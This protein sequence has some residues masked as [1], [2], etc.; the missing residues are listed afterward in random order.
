[1]YKNAVTVIFDRRKT[2]SKRGYGM[3]ELRIFIARNT[4]KYISLENCTPSQWDEAVFSERYADLR[5]KYEDVLAAMEL[6][7]ANMDV[8][9]FCQ[10][11]GLET[12]E[13]A[14]KKAEVETASPSP[15]PQLGMPCFVYPNGMEQM[16]MAPNFILHPSGVM[17]PLQMKDSR[18]NLEQDFLE[19]MQTSI[20]SEN[21]RKGTYKHKQT[22]IEA[23]RRFGKIKTFADLTPQ[24][25][26]A[27]D[28]FL[29]DGLKTDV[30]IYGY[31]KFVKMYCR[32]LHAA[33]MIPYNPYDKVK[34][35]RGKSK[36]REPLTED[37]L[38]A[39]RLTKFNEKLSRVRDLFVFSAY[40]GLSYADAQL[41]DY[42]TMT[43]VH[44]GMHYINGERLK[45]GSKFFTP[46]LEPAMKVLEKYNYQLPN[47]SNQKANDYL[48][49]IE[50]RLKFHKKLT[51]HVARHTFATMALAHDV[52]IT[53]VARMLGH[54]DVKTTQIY[55]KV[56]KAN[57]ER[58]AAKMASA[59]L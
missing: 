58:H 4:Y 46:I 45:T 23:V 40:T 52:P 22:T 2:S 9:T 26:I 50:A 8:A 36:E 3:V 55:A 15:V 20:D 21:I 44:D 49:V 7:H 48:H 31:H 11:A 27:F 47:I 35:K 51:F 33:D 41:F 56:M 42:E 6:L 24:N 14:E 19:Y 13:K 34:I 37:E 43:E 54:Q 57:I 32:Q 59:I 17:Q 18:Y 12:K 10:Y 1:M 5:R 53:N 16:L 30:T 29:H 39:M 28:R 38:M 25:I